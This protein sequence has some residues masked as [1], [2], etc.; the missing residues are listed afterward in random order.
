[1]HIGQDKRKNGRN[2]ENRFLD[3]LKNI[4]QF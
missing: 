3:N 4:H 1:L 2:Y